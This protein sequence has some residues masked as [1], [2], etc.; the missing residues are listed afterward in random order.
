MR[1]T[2]KEKIETVM[3]AEIAE[4]AKPSLA[5]TPYTEVYPSVIC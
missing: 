4:V 2:D 1:K 5:N 3:F